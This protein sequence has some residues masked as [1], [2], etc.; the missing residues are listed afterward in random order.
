MD[1]L[2]KGPKLWLYFLLMAVIFIGKT[3]L[4][5]SP[6]LPPGSSQT[7]TSTLGLHDLAA[8]CA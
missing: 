2:S 3:S 4:V 7:G 5:G 6:F 8:G 1:L